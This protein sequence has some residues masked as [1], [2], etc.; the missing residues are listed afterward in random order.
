MQ[1]ASHLA[2]GVQGHK[3]RRLSRASLPIDTAELARYLIGKTI[4][5]E[6]KSQYSFEMPI[7]SDSAAM[8]TRTSSVLSWERSY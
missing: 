1:T 4:V 2:R 3:V 6:M 5:R 7:P 8:R